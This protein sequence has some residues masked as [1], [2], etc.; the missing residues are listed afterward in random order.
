MIGMPKRSNKFYPRPFFESDVFWHKAYGEIELTTVER[1]GVKNGLRTDYIITVFR[2]VYDNPEGT[3][4]EQI[5]T[6]KQLDLKRIQGEY[7]G[8]IN[9]G[10]T[11]VNFMGITY[12]GE[13]RETDG[14]IKVDPIPNNNNFTEIGARQSSLDRYIRSAHSLT[15]PELAG[16]ND[17][18]TG[19]S[20]IAEV[21]RVGAEVYI[22]N[23]I[24]PHIEKI[25]EWHNTIINANNGFND[26]ETFTEPRV[27]AL[28]ALISEFKELLTINEFRQ[29]ILSM[30]PLDKEEKEDL[31]GS[32]A[33]NNTSKGNA[34]ETTVS[35]NDK[36]IEKIAFA[37][38][39]AVTTK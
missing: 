17:S 1:N 36:T 14:N 10:R 7:A 25:D 22:G 12:E 6:Q 30:G 27:I 3:T 20:N 11:Q 32:K 21:L 18:K 28:K 5:K 24:M 34:Q 19:F 15:V 31:I 37:V 8:Y 13:I 26:I 2:S 23:V 9:S 39:E 33:N 16:L 29:R 35:V 38:K 4:T